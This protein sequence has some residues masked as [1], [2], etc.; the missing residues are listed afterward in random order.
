MTKDRL[1]LEDDALV[2]LDA[3]GRRCEA[4]LE[5]ARELAVETRPGQASRLLVFGRP[6]YAPQAAP[7]D[8]GGL[9][10]LIGRLQSFPQFDADAFARALAKSDRGRTPVLRRAPPVN[11]RLRSG[12]GA[13]AG[14]RRALEQDL[15]LGVR[16]P[17]LRER[18]PWRT[19]LNELASRLPALPDPDRP[20]EHRVGPVLVGE[21]EIDDMF[22]V[23]TRPD[24]P[25]VMWWAEVVLLRD[26]WRRNEGAL[27]GAARRARRQ[28][29]LP[30]GGES[31][32]G[33]T[34]DG[35]TLALRYQGPTETAAEA[36]CCT[37]RLTNGRPYPELLTDAYCDFVQACDVEAKSFPVPGLRTSG[38]FRLSPQ[39]R[40]TPAGLLELFA[41]EDHMLVWRDKDGGRIG[42]AD[43][44]HAFIYLRSTVETV[45]LQRARLERSAAR[46]DLARELQ[47]LLALDGHAVHRR[48]LRGRVGDVGGSALDLHP[49]QQTGRYERVQLVVAIE[50][51]HGDLHDEAPW[52]R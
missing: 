29:P 30:S 28:A 41:G 1:W 32:T 11:A 3:Q 36:G 18:L 52:G 34:R 5:R 47:G 40:T 21:L 50:R 39:L 16:H 6:G 26:G 12:L 35:I 27:R 43:R 22:V 7:L 51:E 37:V 10:G 13:T 44:D 17:G 23:K 49:V 33:W 14:G 24:T 48:D 2:W 8:R 46:S 20:H 4:D 45:V 42:L 19:S 15:A 25:L 9:D 31:T 38:D